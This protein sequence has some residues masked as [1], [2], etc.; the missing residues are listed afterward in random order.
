MLL[1]VSCIKELPF[2]DK[3]FEKG[4][5]LNT[6]LEVGKPIRVHVSETFAPSSNGQASIIP[7]ATV[8]LFDSI[9][10]VLEVLSFESQ[11]A[12][13]VGKTIIENGTLY[14]VDADEPTSLYYCEGSDRT[15]LKAAS[16][17]VDTS[18]LTFQ[19]LENF[20]QFDIILSD[21]PNERNFY[22]FYCKRSYF[23]Y[24]YKNGV[25]SDSVLLSEIM[26]LKTNDFWF[27]R[28]N[29]IQYSRKELLLVDEG[30]AGQVAFLKF[31]TY[32]PKVKTELERTLSITL[33]VNSLSLNHFIYSSSLNE[34]IF[35]QS[36]PFSQS[37]TV[38]S[39]IRGGFG[40]VGS[41]HSDSL[42]YEF[43]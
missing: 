6:I 18:N 32:R 8:K 34:H 40:I 17:I 36:D 7:N 19:G 23:E 11:S 1:L 15:P 35:Y 5:T 27:V 26:D 33:F 14:K 30:F 25:L 4:I 38:F 3:P 12:N 31:G 13:Y 29:N 43:E 42:V 22:Q 41:S 16:F 20:F 10:N 39:N 2:P 28:N 24:I 9:G 21:D 37:T